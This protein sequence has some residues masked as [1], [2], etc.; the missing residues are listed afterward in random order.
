MHAHIQNGAVVDYPYFL[1][2]TDGGNPARS[3]KRLYPDVSPLPGSWDRC[4][5]DQLAALNA[6]PVSAVAAPTLQ[7]GEMLAEGTPELVG[8]QWQQSW[9]VTPAPEPGVPGVPES[10]PAHHL[11]RAL[12][13]FGMRAA[14][15]AHIAELPADDPMRDDWQFAPYF[16]RDALGIEAARVALGLTEAQVNALFVAA[17]AVQA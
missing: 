15:E 16:R 1:R 4:S 9:V 2:G 17:V 6:A 13:Q 10:V 12:T 3:A 5:A 8:G 11:R 7:D 14:V